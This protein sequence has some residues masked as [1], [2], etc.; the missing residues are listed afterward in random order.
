MTVIKDEL[1]LENNARVEPRAIEEEMKSS[2]IDYA[3]SVI[4]GRALPDARDGLKPVHRRILYTMD[5]MGLAYNKPH[6]KSA[7]VV[8]DC[9]GKYHPHGD[10]S[11][12]EALIRMAQDFSMEKVLVDGQGN[13]GSIDG[14]PPAAM[15]YT[16]VRLAKVVQEMMADLDKN[17]VDFVPN[18]DGSL[19]E[20][21]VL[22]ANLPNLLVN[23]SSG[24]A[25]GM[26]TN[27]PTHNLA[28]TC[29]AAMAYI[30]N[31]EIT[32]D[33]LMQIMIGP[34]FP[35]GGLVLGTQGIRDYYATGRGSFTIRAKT[36]IE[37]TKGG[38]TA[39]IVE[40]V[41]Y[42]VNKAAMLETMAQLVRDKKI[43]DV[44][45]LRDESNREGVRMVIEVKRDGN[46]HVVLNQ[47]YRHTQMET[48]FSVILLAIVNDQPKVLSLK[49]AL[50]CYVEHRHEVVVRRTKFDLAKAQERAHIVEGLRIAI[51]NINKVIKII[52]EAKDTE[53][54]R[55]ALMEELDLSFRQANAILEMRLGQLTGLERRKLDEEYKELLKTI[56]RL[57]L[58]LESPR[59]ILEII[60]EELARLKKDY[61]EERKTQ[62]IPQAEET[63]I[64][65]LIKKEEVVVSI[66]NQGYIKRLSVDVYRAQARGG[67][68]ITATDTREGE[69]FIEEAM[70]TDTHAAMLFF[71]NRGRVYQSRVYEIPESSRISRGK[72]VIQLIGIASNK[73][74]K[75][76]GTV[77][78]RSFE[79]RKA[80]FLV[81]ATRRGVIKRC[82]VKHFQHI[83]KTGVVAINLKEGD[84]LVGVA[85]T[86]GD[87]EALLATKN[88]KSIRFPEA[89]LRPMGR[90]SYGV[91]GIRLEPSDEVIGLEIAKKSDQ[92][93]LLTVCQNGYGKR[94]ALEEY[95]GQSR[96]GSGTIT[97]KATERNGQVI[98]IKLIND[99]SDLMVLTEK[100]MGV[101]LRAKDINIIS[102]NTQGVRLIRLENGDRVACVEP[103]A[104][105]NNGNH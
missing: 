76:T 50:A 28:E 91:R 7:R 11:V 64:E 105:T 74:E 96:G 65:D 97:I 54:A 102:R 93:T 32:T 78:I 21:R 67:K 82:D 29:E 57:A 17:T 13:M 100:G 10:S 38:K 83:R 39:I 20:P 92:R 37:E 8:G 66:S 51:E 77:T 36:Q 60:K 30:D 90:V 40:E 61:G 94:T 48:S 1:P 26:A 19:M 43:T 85:H 71:T 70:V 6:K 14:D 42:Q 63:K 72:P 101:R 87:G 98:G 2:Y 88:G 79:A 22:P 73:E 4:V 25:V 84:V 56:D 34:D 86:D 45:D 18:Y 55:K 62:I 104:I 59:R 23:G 16:E 35:T 99:T 27:I 52:R 80:G 103:I 44:S 47:L 9:L 24:I 69:D 89:Q 12:Y 53:S 5:E 31:N 81:L 95:R 3:M 49:D 68:G 33:E 41:P 75:I 58:I 46:P 15:R